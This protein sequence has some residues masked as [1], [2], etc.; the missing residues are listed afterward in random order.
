VQ[1]AAKTKDR[2]MFPKQRA[3]NPDGDGA[4]RERAQ[5]SGD[6]GRWAEVLFLAVT[7]LYLY[8]KLFTFRG[9]PILLG[10]DQIFFWMD[11]KRLLLGERIYLDFFQFTPPGTD[12][13]YLAFFK[14]FGPRIWVPNLIVL[15]LGVLFGWVCFRISISFLKTS[16][17]VLA[18]SMF[19]VF[20][21]GTLLNATH[22]LFSEIAV[23]G[24]VAVL[25][26]GKSWTRVALAGALLGLATFFTQTRGPIAALAIAA[27]FTW[28]QLR[29]RGPWFGYFR[30]LTLLFCSLIF[31]WFILSGYFIASV[32]LGQ[33]WK[34]QVVYVL[35]QKVAEGIGFGLP[36]IFSWRGLSGISK[37]TDDLSILFL[38]LMLPV[39]YIVTLW[40]CWRERAAVSPESALGAAYRGRRLVLLAFVG[41]ATALEMTPSLT[42]FRLYCVAAPGVLL[43][44]WAVGRVP[45]HQ[46]LI[47]NLLWI[48]LFCF[49]LGRNW[50]L[51]RH[52]FV[53]LDAPAGTVAAYPEQAEK[54]SW[55]AQRTR[56]GDYFFQAGW[57]GVY[58][59][60]DL[61]NPVYAES[62]SPF[63]TTI[64]EIVERS[65]GQ[66]ESRQVRY[67]LWAPFLNSPIPPGH[68]EVYHLTPLRDYM[69]KN[70]QKV[71]TFK[72]GDE[73]WQR[74]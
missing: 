43:F 4:D 68:P 70:Y 40:L 8:V 59:P 48:G 22:H 16:R 31:S 20:I 66:L 52:Q 30:R 14:L 60:L 67:I 53:T 51:H 49:A 50:S 65:I 39:V 38:C 62:L 28:D 55:I 61:N 72:D 46:R 37:L 64:P 17:A 71:W 7:C 10:G 25:V 63:N 3:P 12:V 47:S 9:I 24:A 54:L 1:D 27:Y 34:W 36:H 32:G 15:I 57:P 23:L 13:V 41:I 2:G 19:T 42:W 26:R 6:G 45:R 35:H 44:V 5:S 56:P 33:M 18:A 29:T 21:Y 69:S 11:A 74:K 73:M 58:L